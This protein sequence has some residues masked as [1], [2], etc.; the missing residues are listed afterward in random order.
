MNQY[1]V[2]SRCNFT[3][4]AF[5]RILIVNQLPAKIKNSTLIIDTRYDTSL[6]DVLLRLKFLSILYPE[7]HCFFIT[8]KDNHHLANHL[9]ENYIDEND[10]LYD[11]KKKLNQLSH[12]QSLLTCKQ[13]YKAIIHGLRLTSAQLRV[14]KDMTCGLNTNDIAEKHS[15]NVKTIYTH[16]TT[17]KRKL[18]I[19]ER[20]NLFHYIKENTPDM[21]QI[22]QDICHP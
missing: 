19:P 7:K 21:K 3:K 17:L 15:L 1:H 12:T 6:I 20:A 22:T 18:N 8:N 9:N 2:V 4:I 10:S 5:H 11:I 14:L 13:Y 16:A